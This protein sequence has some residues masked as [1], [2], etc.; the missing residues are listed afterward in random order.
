MALQALSLVTGGWESLELESSWKVFRPPGSLIRGRPIRSRQRILGPHSSSA[1]PLIY[2]LAGF[3][4]SSLSV[5]G[6]GEE[7]AWRIFRSA[8]Q[9]SRRLSSTAGTS[10]RLEAPKGCPA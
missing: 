8:G 6:G 7:G 10:G 3:A 9:A 2:R 5:A 1:W 4:I